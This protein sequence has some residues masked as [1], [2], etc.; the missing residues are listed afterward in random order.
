ME[1]RGGGSIPTILLLSSTFDCFSTRLSTLIPYNTLLRFK[2]ALLGIVLC[3]T[4]QLVYFTA[5]PPTS[6]LFSTCFATLSPTVAVPYNRSVSQPGNY[7][8]GVSG[9]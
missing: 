4:L 7:Q 1:N 3:N 6:D 5:N 8:E 9:V 2:I